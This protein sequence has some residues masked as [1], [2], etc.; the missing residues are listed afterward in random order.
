MSALEDVACV[1]AGLRKIYAG[2]TRETAVRQMRS[3]W[4]AAF[5]R[6]AQDW[7]IRRFEIGGMNAEWIAAPD[8]APDRIILFLHG[9]GFRIGSI[10]SHRD[11][12]Q[13]LSQAA[14]ASVLA[15]DYRLSPEH[16]FP[17]PVEDA[18]AAYRWLLDQGFSARRIA[19][20]GDSAGG[21]LALSLM[22]ATRA[23]NLPLPCA[24]FLM[25]PWTD[26]TASG[27]SY[28]RNAA[29]D[30]LHQRAMIL[31]MAKGYLGAA[32]DPR[33]PLA[34]PLF[35]DLR[36]LPPLLL[37]CGAPEVLVDDCRA[38][39]DRARA[40]GV[41]VETDI[42]EDMIH[43]FQ[44]YAELAPAQTTLARAGAFLDARWKD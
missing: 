3:D 24:A 43:V 36:G 34:S 25:S 37:Q 41:E 28:A 33:D 20:A 9:G 7:P 21:G 1:V 22:L 13:R 23:K 11:L 27:A 38:L 2:W 40:C 5:A 32:G 15:V 17:A 12:I 8:A 6:R 14:G 44:S 31:G 29:S 16:D 30:P 10:C 4:D 39:A 42:Y 18:L 19:L 35:A 26:M